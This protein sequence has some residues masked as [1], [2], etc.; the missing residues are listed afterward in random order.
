M[1]DVRCQSITL[2]WDIKNVGVCQEE[3]KSVL[4]AQWESADGESCILVANVTGKEQIAT[5]NG[6][7]VIVPAYAFTKI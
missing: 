1:L 7:A 2:D 5:I 3:E 4:A 6:K